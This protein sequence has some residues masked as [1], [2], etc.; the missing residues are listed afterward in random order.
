MRTMTRNRQVF[1]SASLEAV[2]MSTDT[3][4]NY[5]EE[6]FTYSKPVK[7]YGVFTPADGQASSQLY[8]MNE[9]Y[10]RVITLNQG[11]TYLDVG[12]IL[13]VDTMPEIDEKT[14]NTDTPYDYIVVK[15][16]VSLNTVS[17]AIRK[18]DVS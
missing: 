4:G 12:S 10:D 17:V 2:G 14:G 11:E 15:K 6:T 5:V 7:R 16:A 1:Y 3:D 13:W 18:V 9:R 8:G